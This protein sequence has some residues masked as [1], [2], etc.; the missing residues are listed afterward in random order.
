MP[1]TNIRKASSVDYW[2]C[3]SSKSCNRNLDS[4]LVRGLKNTDIRN[5][6]L[7]KNRH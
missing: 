4:K 2:F 5:G 7:Y 3:Q 6:V 1:F